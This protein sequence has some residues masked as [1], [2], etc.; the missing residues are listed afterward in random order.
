MCIVEVLYFFHAFKR[1]LFIFLP[2]S[3]FLYPSK[4]NF[5]GMKVDVIFTP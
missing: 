1:L 3:P 5:I 4:I 2:P